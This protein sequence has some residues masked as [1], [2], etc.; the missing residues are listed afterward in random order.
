[1]KKTYLEI[2]SHTLKNKLTNSQILINGTVN[3]KPARVIYYN[4][5]SMSRINKMQK[6]LFSITL[7][8]LIASLT[9]C[10]QRNAIIEHV[11]ELKPNQNKYIVLS[12]NDDGLLICKNKRDESFNLEITGVYPEM[13]NDIT[14]LYRTGTTLSDPDHHITGL[15]DQGEVKIEGENIEMYTEMVSAIPPQIGLIYFYK[16]KNEY[17]AF[18]TKSPITP[19]LDNFFLCHHVT[20]G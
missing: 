11:S 5:P 7:C 2:L 10:A 4:R 6:Q 14:H 20:R 1:M 19:H 8:L 3:Y 9:G 18:E 16:N 12:Q 13:L 17:Y 15:I